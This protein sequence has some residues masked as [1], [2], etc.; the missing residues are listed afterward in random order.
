MES[1]SVLERGQLWWLYD[2][3]E[4]YHYLQFPYQTNTTATELQTF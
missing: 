4:N 3:S 1:I 2:I